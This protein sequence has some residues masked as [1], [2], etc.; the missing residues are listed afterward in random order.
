M[1]VDCGENN[2][3]GYDN[4][5][6]SGWA[7]RV[8]EG[9]ST[10]ALQDP[11]VQAPFYLSRYNLLPLS[12]S[13]SLVIPPPLAASSKRMRGSRGLELHLSVPCLSSLLKFIY[14]FS[15]PVSPPLSIS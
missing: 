12:I 10:L 6:D 7:N 4:D 13:L 11:F 9:L 5:N 2:S 1:K 8:R 15:S 14:A 3:T